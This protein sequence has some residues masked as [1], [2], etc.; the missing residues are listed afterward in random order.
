MHFFSVTYLMTKLVV[1]CSVGVIQRSLFR[2]DQVVD[3]DEMLLAL[4][5]IKQVV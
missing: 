5:G 2:R 1:F 3:D 4:A